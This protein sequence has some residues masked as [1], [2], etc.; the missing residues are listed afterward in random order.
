MKKAVITFMIMTALVSVG[1]ISAIA[2]GGENYIDADGNGVCDYVEDTFPSASG[3]CALSGYSPASASTV[4]SQ[5]V[6][7]ANYV[8]ADNDGVCDNYESGTC[9]RDGTGNQMRGS[10]GKSR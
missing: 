6:K 7:G 8:D 9:P 2:A 4:F 1:T 5:T 3:S 10:R